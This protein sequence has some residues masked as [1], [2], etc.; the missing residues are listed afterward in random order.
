M[1]TVSYFVVVAA[2]AATVDL[3]DTVADAVGVEVAAEA[4]LHAVAAAVVDVVAVGNSQKNAT[5]AA[6]A[7]VGSP[8]MTTAGV[9]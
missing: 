9:D 4:G 8:P 2:A 3:E 7:A 6:A 5:I 1:I